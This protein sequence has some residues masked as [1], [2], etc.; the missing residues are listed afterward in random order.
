MPYLEVQRKF[1]KFVIDSFSSWWNKP[2]FSP[3]DKKTQ[4]T[5]PFCS[6]TNFSSM[7]KCHM[8]DIHLF[9]N[10]PYCNP[11]CSQARYQHRLVCTPHISTVRARTARAFLDIN[12]DQLSFWSSGEQLITDN[13][14]KVIS[15][16][17][18]LCWIEGVML[19]IDCCISYQ[20]GQEILANERYPRYRMY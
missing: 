3:I 11:Q 7:N 19:V 13:H 8:L 10:A 12:L 2:L 5:S 9:T 17:Y 1:Y 14:Q 16:L 6:K 18:W 15:N 20:K 4:S